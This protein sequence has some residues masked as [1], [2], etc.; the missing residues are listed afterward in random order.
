[1]C[2]LPYILGIIPLLAFIIIPV[3]NIAINSVLFGISIM[4]MC[5]IYPD[6]YNAYLAL[7]KAPKK[8]NIQFY[9]DGMYYIE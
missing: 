7:T 4:G 5:S 8:A 3:N 2:L 9:K 6:L 1:L